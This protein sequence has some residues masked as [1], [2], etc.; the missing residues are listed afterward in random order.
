M[1][2]SQI[3]TFSNMKTAATAHS[4]SS[5]LPEGQT[6]IYK[7]ISIFQITKAQI[8]SLYITYVRMW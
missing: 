7:K 4:F 5:E 6:L 3:H 1:Q 2:M 8:W